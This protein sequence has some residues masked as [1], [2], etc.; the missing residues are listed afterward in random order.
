MRDIGAKLVKSDKEL[1]PLGQCNTCQG[2]GV[3]QPYA[4]YV[5]HPLRARVVPC[6]GCV[7]DELGLLGKMAGGSL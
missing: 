5:D 3:I 2:T 1:A 6:P 4:N 7:P